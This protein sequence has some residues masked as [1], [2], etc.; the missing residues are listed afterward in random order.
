MAKNLLNCK[1]EIVF[2]VVVNDAEAKMI[3]VGLWSFDVIKFK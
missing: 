2:H 1:F 3:M